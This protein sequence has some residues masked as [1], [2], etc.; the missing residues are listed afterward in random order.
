M[1]RLIVGTAA[2]MMCLVGLGGTAG[3]D[4]VGTP[5]EPN[6]HGVRVSHGSSDHGQ[7]P[8]ERVAELNFLLDL[9]PNNLPPGFPPFIVFF[10]PILHDFFGD[11]AT[12]REFHQWVKM[13]CEEGP[14]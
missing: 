8:V 10:L 1:K 5:G 2:L 12:V 3:A 9:D 4:T 11:E 6:C 14:N 7:T 13:N